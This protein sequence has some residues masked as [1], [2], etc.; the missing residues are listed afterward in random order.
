MGDRPTSAATEPPGGASVPAG[1]AAEVRRSS[2][3]LPVVALVVVGIVLALVVVVVLGTGEDGGGADDGTT[4]TAGPVA[5][6]PFPDEV[7][8]VPPR[9][10]E[11]GLVWSSI[12][13]GATY[14]VSAYT[15]TNPGIPGPV[16]TVTGTQT[17]VV[18]EESVGTCFEVRI[19]GATDADPQID[20]GSCTPGTTPDAVIER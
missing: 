10:T 2:S 3:L 20:G 19:E 16:V 18:T 7:T 12:S 9:G 1:G 15:D 17:T 14:V 13:P 4:T 11:H 5:G 8:L 6:S